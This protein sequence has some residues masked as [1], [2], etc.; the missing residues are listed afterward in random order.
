M[1]C[2]GGRGAAEDRGKDHGG[3]TT[4]EEAQIEIREF[5]PGDEESLLACFNEVF[6]QIDVT[7]RPRPMEVWRWAFDANPAGR[8]VFV[9]VSG[10]R[11]VAQY[12]SLPVRM[13]VEGADSSFGQIVDS[14]AHPEFRQGL[15][16]PG[17]FVR[18]AWPFF[19][20][21]GG[22]EKDLVMFGLPV[23]QAWRVGKSFLKYEMVRELCTLELEATSP[24]FAATGAATS[25][26]EVVET[27]SVGPW[28]DNLWRPWS[29]SQSCVAVRDEAYLRWRY[30]DKPDHEYR[31]AIVR[32][33]GGGDARG[34]AVVR[35]GSFDHREALLLV[36]WM[37]PSGDAAAGAALLAWARERAAAERAPRLTALFPT[38]EPWFLAFQD[39]GFRVRPTSYFL[40]ARHF[41]KR[42][43]M[44]WLRGHWY[45]TLGDF[46][47]V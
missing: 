41:A 31:F 28:I 6:A 33:R 3:P 17:L 37:V 7:F 32:P 27:D 26:L 30:T 25:E 24:A 15:K 2:R 21:Y 11:V 20:A 47:L 23:P 44:G 39:A 22:A 40:V 34:M 45:Y 14:M 38:W 12:A 19:D 13:R 35:R 4:L 8:R 5:R 9:A 43:D 10:E 18:T 42:Y 46:D 29:A 1:A 16:Q 36:D